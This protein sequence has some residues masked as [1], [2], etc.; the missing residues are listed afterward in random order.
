VL[1]FYYSE[2]EREIKAKKK[3]SLKSIKMNVARICLLACI[4]GAL[5]FSCQVDA[6]ARPVTADDL[7]IPLPMFK[8]FLNAFQNQKSL[9]PSTI[10]TVFGFSEQAL[11]ALFSM[12]PEA[13]EGLKNAAG[14][15]M[16][17]FYKK[18]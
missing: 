9:T 10:N 8:Q 12:T 7:G 5:F 2:L 1:S 18:F 11:Q 3:L 15:R 17:K 16:M 14:R 6:Q 4:A 13:V